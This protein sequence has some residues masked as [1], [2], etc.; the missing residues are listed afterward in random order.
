MSSDRPKT[1]THEPAPAAA[2]AD[3]RLP[4]SPPRLQLFGPVGA[5][6]QGGS[7]TASESMGMMILSGGMLQRA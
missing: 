3:G 7:G 2:R 1:R 4:Y 5:L 6:T